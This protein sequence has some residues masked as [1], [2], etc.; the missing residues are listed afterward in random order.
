MKMYV[1]MS[2]CLRLLSWKVDGVCEWKWQAMVI[3]RAAFSSFAVLCETHNLITKIHLSLFHVH[4]QERGCFPPST[5]LSAGSRGLCVGPGP[6]RA[7][8]APFRGTLCFP[9][10]ARFIWALWWWW[11]GKAEPEVSVLVPELCLGL[12][13]KAL[14]PKWTWMCSN[15]SLNGTLSHRPWKLLKRLFI[16]PKCKYKSWRSIYFILK[17]YCFCFVVWFLSLCKN[18]LSALAGHELG[19]CFI[20]IFQNTSEIN[21]NKDV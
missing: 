7:A 10:Y 19:H 3:H 8:A 13:R 14:K 15:A 11:Q 12:W 2:W 1:R 16:K 6:C 4:R 9:C 20:G 5:P 18:L 21:S 17:C